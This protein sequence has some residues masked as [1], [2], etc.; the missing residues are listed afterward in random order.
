LTVYT[1]AH[2]YSHIHEM[3]YALLIDW[4]VEEN[5]S[6]WQTKAMLF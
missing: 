5:I 1:N 4:L 3:K 6:Q 2:K